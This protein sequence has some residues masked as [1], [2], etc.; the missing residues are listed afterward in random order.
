MQSL[1]PRPRTSYSS[2]WRSHGDVVKHIGNQIWDQR[3]T[4]IL[5]KIKPTNCEKMSV[6]VCGKEGGRKW[7]E[8]AGVWGGG[9]AKSWMVGGQIG[10]STV[11]L[12]LKVKDWGSA[13]NWRQF[14]QHV[15]PW[16]KRKRAWVVLHLFGVEREGNIRVEIARVQMTMVFSSKGRQQNHFQVNYVIVVYVVP[17]QR[18]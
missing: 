2:I 13:K 8:G 12:T 16:S 9:Q 10:K 3:V 18:L 15:V 7:K 1:G 5:V 14:P 6:S 17:H 4:W 11:S